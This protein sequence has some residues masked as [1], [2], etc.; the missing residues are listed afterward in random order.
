MEFIKSSVFRALRSHLQDMSK[1]SVASF[2]A[3]ALDFIVFSLFVRL[4]ELPVQRGAVFGSLAGGIFH[5]SLCR[6]W[7]FARFERN[8]LEAAFRYAIVSGSALVLHSTLTTLLATYL[9]DI[10]ETAWLT[11]KFLVFAFWIYPGSKYMVFGRSRRFRTAR[12]RGYLW[13]GRLRKG[14]W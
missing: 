3:T 11:S 4:F 8:L 1:L 14:R 12:R 7:V 13:F 10:E 2:L 5:F 6:F 9:L